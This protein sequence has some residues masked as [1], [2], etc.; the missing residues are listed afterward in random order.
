MRKEMKADFET[1]KKLYPKILRIIKEYDEFFNSPID[2]ESAEIIELK[3]KLRQIIGEKFSDDCIYPYHEV[4]SAEEYA[5]ELGLPP[6]QLVEN[7]T[8]EELIEILE[9]ISNVPVVIINDIKFD[10]SKF[11]LKFLEKNFNSFNSDW[12]YYPENDSTIEELSE[13]ILTYKNTIYL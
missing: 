6:P 11:Y 7:I 9:I 10:V 3:N 4:V 13:K 2:Y 1:A 12:I 8:K 5:L